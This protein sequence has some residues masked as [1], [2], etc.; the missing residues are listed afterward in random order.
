[1]AYLRM[2]ALIYAR[3]FWNRVCHDGHVAMKTGYPSHING[4]KLA[5]GMLFEDI[6]A[7][8]GEEDCTHF[9]SCCVG[10][11]H[12]KVHIN[13]REIIYQGGGLA[14]SCPFK[15]MGIYGETYAPRGVG[16]LLAHGGKIVKPQFQLTSDAS[17]RDAIMSELRPGDVVA[18]ASKDKAAHYEHMALLVNPGKI[19]CHTR[20]RYNVD[21]A[22]IHWPWI[23]LI[24]LP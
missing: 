8:T 9:L 6:G 4:V 23:T 11:F 22:N 24:R 10:R 17:T 21:Y 2:H 18:Y 1:M 16:A 3:T 15:R 5:P 7:T 13:G 12:A 14:I 19:A 20:M